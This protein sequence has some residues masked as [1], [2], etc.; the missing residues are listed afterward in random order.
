[1]IKGWRLFFY[2]VIGAAVLSI[3]YITVKFI[4]TERLVKATGDERLEIRQ[5]AARKV[6]GRAANNPTQRKKAMDF[7]T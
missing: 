6:M 2:T 7:F 1:M 5:R 3:V 4:L